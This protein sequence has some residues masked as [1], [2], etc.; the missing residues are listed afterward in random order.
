MSKKPLLSMS[1]K[2][3]LKKKIKLNIRLRRGQ[4]CKAGRILQTDRREKAMDWDQIRMFSERK[5]GPHAW[6]AGSRRRRTSGCHHR[7]PGTHSDLATPLAGL[8]PT[9]MTARKCKIPWWWG[10]L[11]WWGETHTC[12]CTIKF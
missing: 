1:K 3:S 4:P 11:G 2:P 12:T 10:G 7:G 6:S 9:A 5:G 8:P